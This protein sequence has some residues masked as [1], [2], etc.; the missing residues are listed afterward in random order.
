MSFWEDYKPIRVMRVEGLLLNDIS[1]EIETRRE[2]EQAK[3]NRLIEGNV[4]NENS[5]TVK[6]KV[7]KSTCK[8]LDRWI[9][10]KSWS[11]CTS[12]LQVHREKMEPNFSTK[13]ISHTKQCVCTTERYL[14]PKVSDFDVGWKS[15]F[16]DALRLF[17]VETGT[18]SKPP[19]GYR[20]RT[21]PIRLCVVL[22]LPE[23]RIALIRNDRDREIVSSLY[24]I[25]LENSQHYN[26]YYT[27]VLEMLACDS[28][29][30]PYYKAFSFEC[31]EVA[32]WPLLYVKEEWCESA[33]SGHASRLSAKKSFHYKALS[34]IIDYGQDFSLIQFQF[35][36]YIFKTVCGA[37]ESGKKYKCSPIRSLETK[38]FTCS[39]WKW[40]HLLLKDAV[41]QFGF[42]SLFVT[43]SPA[44][45]K[46]P[47][48]EWL[49]KRQLLVSSDIK[50]LPYE[51]TVHILHV[52]EQYC[53]GYISGCNSARW[54]HHVVS[55]SRSPSNGNVVMF[56]YRFEFQKRG[57][58]HVHMLLWLKSMKNLHPHRFS[59][60]VTNDNAL[61]N[62][63]VSST[64][65]S[66]KPHKSITVN[67]SDTS[68]HKDRINFHY[69][70]D[71]AFVNRRAYIDTVLGSL[72]C[73]MDVQCAD[74]KDMLLRYTTSYVSK[75]KDHDLLYDSIMKEVSGYHI[76][77]QYMSALDV[78]VPEMVLLFSDIKAAYTKGLTKKFSVPRIEIVMRCTAVQKYMERP[79][80]QKEDTFL[81]FLRT[82][83]SDD[84]F[85][86]YLNKQSVLVAC[87][88]VGYF[89]SQ[90]PFQHSLM[91]FPFT[92]LNQLLHPRSEEI[93][94]HLRY[95]ASAVH[96]NP[97]FWEDDD[98]IKDFLI[99]EGNRDSFVSSVLS[100][101]KSIRTSLSLYFEGRFN[102]IPLADGISDFALS[103]QDMST[104][105]RRIYVTITDLLSAYEGTVDDVDV[106]LEDEDNVEGSRNVPHTLNN[107]VDPD[108]SNGRRFLLSGE[109]GSGKSF[110]IKS[111]MAFC[112]ERSLKVT[113]SCPTGK[114]ASSYA[115]CFPDMR[116]DTVHSNFHIPVGEVPPTVNWSLSDTHIFIID[117]ITQVPLSF[118]RHI[119]LTRDSMPLNPVILFAGDPYQL[120]PLETV[121]SGT[122]VGNSMFDEEQL[123]RYFIKFHLS[124]QH[125]CTNKYSAF[126]NNFRYS[127]PSARYIDQ[128]NANKIT[129]DFPTE[130][131]E[132]LV[133]KH[134]QTNPTTTF[135]VL[136]NAMESFIN[137]ACTDFFFKDHEGFNVLDSDLSPLCLYIGLPVYITENRCKSTKYVNGMSG[138]IKFCRSSTFY[139]ESNDSLIP[140]FPVYKDGLPY[141]PLRPGYA[142]T[143]HKIQGQTLS[144]VTLVFDRPS[145]TPA[146]GYVSISRVPSIEFVV[147]M[148]EL[149]RSHF[150]AKKKTNN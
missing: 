34:P 120:Q 23:E 102:R 30:V 35:D 74:G 115:M 48:S 55:D 107:V 42:P 85:S 133:H 87:R 124:S 56:F 3:E 44:E 91:Q 7:W 117:E 146:L 28:D 131:T 40:Q 71:D 121:N 41:V 110:V 1:G 108:D 4:E 95:I 69:S 126:L 138:T 75:M 150:Y 64:Q 59:A 38:S 93:P 123:C 98:C 149:Q 113:L 97:A 66:S 96:C 79:P 5:N 147:P 50:N 10:D 111:I 148:L 114:L 128:L 83:K 6:N 49:H 31:I 63:L 19:H 132:T 134:C 139:I 109:A 17:R 94:E 36:R 54:K 144:H 52:L 99:K 60:S 20:K 2:Q 88:Y 145:L 100:Y 46:F 129:V 8:S 9:T 137:T 76:G 92:D 39:Y 12:C 81:H 112:R 73:H 89:H 125:R 101:F 68:F 135:L 122:V 43:I 13:T 104:S 77:N 16:Q 14:V 78:N 142:T 141:Y 82:R 84:D 140:V 24:K 90:Y 136:T 61:L 118:I 11:Y 45:W 72:K 105:Q 127:A 21:G 119:L 116:C 27:L 33:I 22:P 58:P 51:T 86:P 70:S 57:T 62:D 25:L 80:G 130:V 53:R 32:I 65:S 37:V 103:I 29:T 67:D 18:F 47:Q 15:S 143:V 106:D 26:E